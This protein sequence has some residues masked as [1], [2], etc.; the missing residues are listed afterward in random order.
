MLN[1]LMNFG[2]FF[3]I[4]YNAANGDDRV[5][6][7]NYHQENSETIGRNFKRNFHRK[8]NCI[9]NK[10]CCRATKLKYRMPELL[11]ISENHEGKGC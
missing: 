1:V 10:K 3:L 8:L 9:Y 6:K 5:D 4:L 2:V 7:P 11:V